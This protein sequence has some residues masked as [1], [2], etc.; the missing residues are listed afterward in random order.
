[1]EIKSRS[2]RLFATAVGGKAIT[3]GV[4]QLQETSTPQRPTA[5][6]SCL[7]NNISPRAAF[8]VNAH[9]H[10]TPVSLLLDTG[11]AVTLLRADVFNQINPLPQL[12]RYTGA[13][14]LHENNPRMQQ[15]HQQ[16]RGKCYGKWSNSQTPSSLIRKR[17]SFSSC[18]HTLIS[19]PRIHG[20][21]NVTKHY[22][23]TEDA[24]PIR[25]SPRRIPMARRKETQALLDD[26]LQRDI[27]RPST[28]PWAAPIFLMW[29]RTEHFDSALITASSTQ[30]PE[31][32]LILFREW[33]KHWTRWQGRR[34]LAH[35]TL[36]V[37]T[38]R[39]SWQRKTEQRW[40]SQLMRA[41]LNLRSF[42]LDSAMAL[43]LS[44]VLWTQYW[45]ASNGT[46]V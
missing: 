37:A 30:S 24:A 45:L 35:S 31:K 25:H 28:S 17:N 22:I 4:A 20:R 44:N 14:E 6:S 39:W 5:N 27:I 46:P 1:M 42:R 12:T 3:Q 34:C 33:R 32:M 7:V 29:K 36:P 26:M 13:I 16:R 10:S 8:R 38:G 43:P 15:N 2:S 41:C 19:L 21:T 23:D 9:I 18:C 40:P 11:S